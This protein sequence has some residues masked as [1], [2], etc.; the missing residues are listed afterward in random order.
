[1]A[2]IDTYKNGKVTGTIYDDEINVD[3]YTITDKSGKE[4]EDTN[5]K[6]K[7]LT[8]NAKNGTDYITATKYKDKI[9][10]NDGNDIIYSSLGNDTITGGNGENTIIYSGNFD[11]DTIILTKNEKLTIDLQSYGLSDKSELSYKISGNNLVITVKNYGTITLKNFAKSNTTKLTDGVKIQLSADMFIN[12]NI[13]EYLIYKSKDFSSKGKFTGSRFSETIDATGLEKNITIS[14]K[15]GYNIITGTDGYTDKIT[16]GNDGNE[17]TTGYG[18]KTITTGSGADIITINGEGTHKISAG[19]GKNTI[20]LTG[21]RNTVKT[22]KDDDEIYLSGVTVSTIYAG[23]GHNKIYVDNSSEFGAVI[24][25][26]QKVSAINDIIFSDKFT[27]NY[28]LY[29]NGND[30]VIKNDVNLSTLTIN[31]YYKTKATYNFIADNQTL[32]YDELISESKGFLLKGKRTITGTDNNDYII[33]NDYTG[34]KSSNDTIYSGKGN[35]TINAGKG[36][37]SIYISSNSGEKTILNGGGDDVLIFEEDVA[38]DFTYKNNDLYINYG[39]EYDNIIIDNFKTG[40][41]A[42]YIQ[43]GDKKQYIGNLIQVLSRGDS[44]VRMDNITDSGVKLILT[45]TF[46]GKDYEYNIKS[47]SDEQSAQFEYLT[48]GR[49]VIKGDN[50]FIAANDGQKDDII[51]LGDNNKLNTN[52]EDDIVRV[53][54]VIDSAGKYHIKTTIDSEGEIVPIGSNSNTIN[55]G[56][57]NDYIMYYGNNNSIDAGEGTDRVGIVL[58]SQSPETEDITNAEEVR[59]ILSNTNEINNNIGWFNQGGVGG[60]CRLFVLLDSLQR[61]SEEFSLSDYVDI[62]K[63]ENTYSVT[64]KNYSGDNKST[65]ISDNDLSDFK[66]I[67]GDLDV[68]LIDYAMNKLM[69][70]NKVY[71]KHFLEEYAQEMEYTMDIYGLDTVQKAYYNTISNYLFGDKKVTIVMQDGNSQFKENL[72]ELWTK[73]QNGELNNISIGIQANSR[74][75]KQGILKDHAYSL[76]DLTDKTITLINPWDNADHL[77]LDINKF[78]RLSPFV[79]V[80]GTDYYGQNLIQDNGFISIND[81]YIDV[82]NNDVTNFITNESSEGL[83]IQEQFAPDYTTALTQSAGVTEGSDSINL[84]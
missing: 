64:F 47:L 75:L 6:L 43:I 58:Q 12:L 21:G 25:K 79:I 38:L 61:S 9:Y 24:I 5:K 27:N 80:Y 29:K 70:E 28:Y 57:G 68:V 59:N 60:D 30:L 65:I 20:S 56:D 7:G 33:A 45:N 3:G 39:T 10:G 82:L 37:N 48:N 41:S 32:T 74:N 13:D 15:G 83:Y 55:T 16:G 42:K 22:G 51:L 31:K 36:Q 4:I 23:K 2:Y 8:I 1:M 14:A 72:N 50:L 44:I 76:Y 77:T 78:Y 66:N 69:A 35:D 84:F 18:N 71:D 17:I 67:S 54:Y 81:T 53:G 40:L 62:K 11:N 46:D 63:I 73:Y 34:K 26:D 49:L 19:S 52:D